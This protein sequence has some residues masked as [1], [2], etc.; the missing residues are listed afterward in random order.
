V[1]WDFF[2]RTY[3]HIYLYLFVVCPS[4][5][6]RPA[7]DRLERNIRIKRFGYFGEL[8]VHMFASCPRCRPWCSRIRAISSSREVLSWAQN[9]FCLK[10]EIQ[11]DRAGSS[12]LTSSTVALNLIY[13]SHFGSVYFKHIRI[14]VVSILDHCIIF[15]PMHQFCIS[16]P[17][18][19]FWISAS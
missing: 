18:K 1:S 12:G 10:S 14:L 15:G 9:R 2:L 3:I 6:C 19:P 11:L 7:T 5:S 13:R 4:G 17:F 8:C 16:A